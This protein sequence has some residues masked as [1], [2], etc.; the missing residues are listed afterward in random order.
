[1]TAIAGATALPSGTNV[2][3]ASGGQ[4]PVEDIAPGTVLAGDAVLASV[5]E[6][7]P[8]TITEA[9][10]LAAGAVAPEAPSSPLI[11]SPLQWIA[12]ADRLAPVGALVNGTSIQR[13][14]SA[15][16]T[17]FALAANTPSVLLAA[18]V[19]LPLPGPVGHLS[20]FRP[21]VAGP[22]MQA[23][24]ARLLP[25]HRRPCACCSARGRFHLCSMPTGW[26]PRSLPRT[27]RR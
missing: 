22:D 27:A 15:P 25:P 18:G 3:L 7:P 1:M 19:S 11:L 4:R 23:L 20:R 16:P 17:W 26:R 6:L 13:L 24:R 2:A 21:L 10:I 5:T 9:V 14:P 8:G 12:F